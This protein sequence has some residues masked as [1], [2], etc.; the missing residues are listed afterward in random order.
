MLQENDR[1]VV[2][3]AREQKPLGVVRSSGHHHLE[4]GHMGEPALQAL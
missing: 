3:D 1:V 4:A 2:F